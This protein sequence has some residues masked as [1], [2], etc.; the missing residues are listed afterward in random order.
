MATI[1]IRVDDTLK[2]DAQELYKDLGVD[3]STAITMFLKKSVQTQGIPFT[4]SRYNPATMRAFYEAENGL[5]Q[6]FSSVDA[7]F[8]DLNDED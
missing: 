3:L 7:L 2:K 4:V 6:S 8:E 1:S 5:T